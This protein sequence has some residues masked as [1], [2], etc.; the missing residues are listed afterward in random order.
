MTLRT[1]TVDDI[2]AGTDWS[3]VVPGINLLAVQTIVG[4]LNTGLANPNVVIVKD[5][6][7]NGYDLEIIATPANQHLMLGAPGALFN[8]AATA[9]SD[10]LAPGPNGLAL[11]TV[12]MPIDLSGD[13]TL[14]W[15]QRV[16]SSAQTPLPCVIDLAGPDFLRITVDPANSVYLDRIGGAPYVSPNCFIPDSAWHHYAWT[17]DQANQANVA[18][19]VDGVAVPGTIGPGNY[20]P[21]PVGTVGIRW[22]DV[23]GFD[24][25][26]ALDEVA[27]YSRALTAGEIALHFALAALGLPEYGASVLGAGAVAYWHLDDLPTDADRLP[28][29]D[30]FNSA[31][32]LGEYPSP[33]LQHVGTQVQY[34]WFADARGTPGSATPSVVTVGIPPLV[35]PPGYTFASETFGLQP[36]DQWSGVRVLWDDALQSISPGY[37]PYAY[38]PG[39]F[40]TYHQQ[41]G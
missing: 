37:D 3:F 15:W 14:E 41:G 5:S 39:A 20:P 38:P 18:F 7:G 1:F 21:R 40:L 34:T 25:V 12:P 26:G 27:I 9:F 32:L 24:Y 33:Q 8:D 22:G 4:L 36:F 2:P 16:G 17:F 6:S 10:Q 28:T 19:Y 29:L 30:V 13:F 11:T 35:M 31:T 23:N